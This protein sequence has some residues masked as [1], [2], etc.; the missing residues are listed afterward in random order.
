MLIKYVTNSLGGQDSQKDQGFANQPR[1][2]STARP[3][4]DFYDPVRVEK[5]RIMRERVK[6]QYP[7]GPPPRIGLYDDKWSG[8]GTDVR[9]NHG[10]S[11]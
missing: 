6:A 4:L 10:I 8:G 5:R 3:S 9:G 1:H 7:N 2:I 11:E